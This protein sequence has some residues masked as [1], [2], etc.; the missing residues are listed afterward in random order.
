MSAKPRCPIC[1]KPAVKAFRPFCSKGCADADLGRWLTGRYVVKGEDGD[2]AE[3]TAVPD[4]KDEGS[5]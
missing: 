2:A 3:D 4:A 5:S 1:K